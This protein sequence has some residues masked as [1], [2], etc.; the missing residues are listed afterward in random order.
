[1]TPLVHSFAEILRFLNDIASLKVISS[2]S[3][4]DR[5]PDIRL[6]RYLVVVGHSQY[7]LLSQE[8]RFT[9]SCIQN[10]LISLKRYFPRHRYTSEGGDAVRVARVVVIGAAVT[11]D[12][13]E[14]V[15]VAGIRRALPPVIGRPAY[16]L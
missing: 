8:A 1:M 10:A 6:P 7:S 13:T 15:G 9:I 5:A 11:V 4:I 2:I 14:I 3:G 16:R 12:I